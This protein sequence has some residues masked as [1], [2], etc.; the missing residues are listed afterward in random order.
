MSDSR[1]MM[2]HKIKELVLPEFKKIGFSGSFPHLRRITDG[3]I[4]LVT[5]QFDGYGGGFVIEIAQTKNEPF[6]TYWGKVICPDKL[7]AH[8]LNERIRI[9]PKGLRGDSSADDWFRY[10]K[11]GIFVH[12]VY[13]GA[14]KQVLKNVKLIEKIFDD[15]PRHAARFSE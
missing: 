15:W 2:I 12:N 10:D 13:D 7:T 8:D 14:A 4:C 6:T 1:K 11:K 5:F 9:H 3:T